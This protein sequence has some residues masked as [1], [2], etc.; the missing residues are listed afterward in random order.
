MSRAQGMRVAE[1]LLSLHFASTP[2]Q[3]DLCL[4]SILFSYRIKP[5][6]ARHTPEL[7][8]S[9]VIC[10]DGITSAAFMR[11]LALERRGLAAAACCL[12]A[13]AGHGWRLNQSS[14]PMMVCM[15]H[16]SWPVL[17]LCQRSAST[18]AASLHVPHLGPNQYSQRVQHCPTETAFSGLPSRGRAPARQPAS[19]DSLLPAAFPLHPPLSCTYQIISSC[20]RWVEGGALRYTTCIAATVGKRARAPATCA[21]MSNRDAWPRATLICCVCTLHPGELISFLGVSPWTGGRAGCTVAS[22]G[23]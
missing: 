14:P 13:A 5:T 9:P 23:G 3:Q 20:Y 4:P 18:L 10:I 2:P 16:P 15:G 7:A 22:M 1:A 11:L 19:G 12:V 21:L 8:C 6:A 17:L